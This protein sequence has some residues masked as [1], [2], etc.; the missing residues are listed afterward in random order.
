MMPAASIRWRGGCPSRQIR[1]CETPFALSNWKSHSNSNQPPR[2]WTDIYWPRSRTAIAH[3]DGRT[4]E[5]RALFD[6]AEADHQK[7]HANDE[8]H[9]VIAAEVKALLH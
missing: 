3:R 1:N 6:R 4:D 5:A 2:Q 9:A 8:D 7:N